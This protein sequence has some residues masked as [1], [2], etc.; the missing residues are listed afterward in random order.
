MIVLLAVLIA[1]L[2]TLVF[3]F[4]NFSRSDFWTA[5][6]TP[7]AS[8]IGSGFLVCAPLLAKEFG[9]F[10][11]PAM[12][13]LLVIAYLVG[14]VIRFNIHHV[15]P[16]LEDG[17]KHGPVVVLA[18]I[19]QGV[20]SLAYAVSVAYYLK[21]L[22]A[23]VL[24][25]AENENVIRSN[26][27]V[28][29]IILVC[30]ALSFSG[31][32]RRVEHLAH[33]TVSIKLGVIAGLLAALAVHWVV[34]IG[35]PFTVP[36]GVVSPRNIFILLGLLITVQGFE[37]SRYLGEA[38]DRETRVRT[39]LLAQWISAGIYAVFLILLTPYLTEA[40]MTQ[41]VAGIL[42]IMKSIAPFF[43]GMVLLGAVMSQLSASVAD[44]IGAAG[45]AVEASKRRLS[46]PSGYA[47]GAALSI[48]VVWLTDPFQVIALASRAF[49]LYYAF[50]CVLAIMVARRTK[51]ASVAR[52]LGFAV[53]GLI[54]VIA[55]I[56]G[57]PAE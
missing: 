35:R 6:V 47:I 46:I 13:V 19:S 37:T 24:R 22:A 26:M 31:G 33:A 44:S 54:C 7:L 11:A 9:A 28:T 49:A 40:S 50:Q 41:G 18:R 10:A 53:I 32:L 21:L 45:I 48:A 39:M 25:G 15:E 42:D 55:V 5:T 17:A 34:N 38:Y 2:V 23:F 56:A 20:L 30:V 36:P 8:I 29:A 14:A 4:S 51:S 27:L 12:G 43:G 16:C 1:V 3:A 52:Q 57:S